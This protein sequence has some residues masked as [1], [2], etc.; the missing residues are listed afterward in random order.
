MPPKLR[1]QC[2]RYADTWSTCTD[3]WAPPKL[4]DYGKPKCC[5]EHR[6]RPQREWC[7]RWKTRNKDL[8]DR[9]I[10][11]YYICP[12]CVQKR[13]AIPSPGVKEERDA[14]R[15][16]PVRQHPAYG[17]NPAGPTG[18]GQ[19]GYR[20][21]ALE[22]NHPGYHRQVD[23]SNRDDSGRR[24]H[25]DESGVR[26]GGSREREG[27]DEKQR[28]KGNREQHKERRRRGRDDSQQEQRSERQRDHPNDRHRARRDDGQRDDSSDRHRD[29]RNEG[30]RDHPKERRRDGRD[31]GG[32]DDSN[33]SHR[34]RSSE[35]QR[36]RHKERR[37]DRRDDSVDLKQEPITEG[38]NQRDEGRRRQ[39]IENYRDNSDDIPPDQRHERR[40][41][42]VLPNLQDHLLSG[43]EP[44][45]VPNWNRTA[46]PK[47]R[48]SQH[49]EE[50]RDSISL[51][52]RNHKDSGYYDYK[53]YDKGKYDDGR[54]RS[55]SRSPR[56]D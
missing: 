51:P 49:L 32:R 37:R 12:D 17:E 29:R 36:D 11:A 25:R 34:D 46:K 18:D 9:D 15:K 2:R 4:T 16:L 54:E 10:Q 42:T 8:A 45:I 53:Q 44:Q 55:W 47:P 31:D 26:R 7:T 19:R 6:D 23:H 1:E 33:D 38:Q 28:D 35:G 3:C 5:P 13:L 39:R 43:F 56:R 50:I 41:K 52:H 21:P 27:G 14:E 48:K 22:P 30:Q 20:P 24:R 40:H